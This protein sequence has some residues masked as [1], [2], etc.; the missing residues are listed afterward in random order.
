MDD[1]EICDIGF[2]ENPICE[3]CYVLEPGW[4][5]DSTLCYENCGDNMI[6]G[7]EACDDGNTMP[8]DGC[9]YNCTVEEGFECYFF[10][11]FNSNR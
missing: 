4:K 8:E 5:C 2:D 6:V 10:D 7:A 11:E 1:S 3:E 9:S